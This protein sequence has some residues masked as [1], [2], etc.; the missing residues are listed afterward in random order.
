MRT[1]CGARWQQPRPLG[2]RLADEPEAELLEVAKAAVDEPRRARR[3]PGGDV[4]LLDEGGPQPARHRVEERAAADDPATDDDDVPGAVG[5]SAADGRGA[6]TE[7]DR[8]GRGRRPAA[9]SSLAD[10]P[11]RDPPE[12]PAGP[13][14]QDDDRERRVEDDSWTPV[15]SR[16]VSTAAPSTTATTT[17]A[18]T[19]TSRQ[20][21]WPTGS[22]SGSATVGLGRDPDRRDEDLA[23]VG[24]RRGG[25]SS[26][27]FGRWN[28]TVRSAR[29]AGSDGSPL[30][31]STAVGRVD[32]D[33][34]DAARP[35]LDDELDRRADRVAQRPADPGA[36]QRVDEDRRL[37]DPLPEHRDV[38]G[39]RQVDLADPVVARDAVPV[40]GG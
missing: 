5:E 38:A 36:E 13:D 33:D 24:R 27:V 16:L 7:R 2:E 12:Q 8:V 3:R 21:G 28:V 37:V 19:T 23:R 25:S 18:T 10:R 39:D 20:P 6:A 9:R 11:A 26:P 22:R 30:E 17:S 32:G 15:G 35:G 40:P 4:V 29:T 14:D 1:R 34:R 31:R